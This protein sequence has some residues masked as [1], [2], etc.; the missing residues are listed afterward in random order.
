MALRTDSRPN[1]LLF[2]PDQLRADVVS[3]F[4]LAGSA[5]AR[6][7]ALDSLAERATSFTSA[8]SQHPVCG[9]SRASIMTGWYPHV[10]GHR[11]LTTP[12]RHDEPNLLR[13]CKDAGYH[14]AWAGHRG[15]TFAP[16]V[17]EASTDFSGWL[18]PPR[19]LHSAPTV[20]PGSPLH[21]AYYNGRRPRAVVDFDEATVRT[22]EAWLSSGPPE[23]WLLFV[24]LLFPHCPFETE[25]PWFSLHERQ[26]IPPPAPRG[27]V[28]R[29]PAFKTAL[30]AALGLDDL[31]DADWAELR[32]TY[33]GMVS[34]VDHH[35]GRVLDAVEH[36]GATERT[37][38]AF[39][40]DHGEYAGDQG[41]VEKWPSGLDAC[42]LRN[43]LLVALPGQ[44]EAR[45]CDALVEMVDLLPTLCTL[46]GVPVPHQH[47]GHDLGPLIDGATTELRD[48]AFSE[49]GFSRR[50]AGRLEASAGRY[51]A[52]GELQRSQPDLVGRAASVRTQ[53]WTYVHRL[54]EGPELYDRLADPFETVNLAGLAAQADDE[55]ELRHRLLEW[56]LDTAD[57]LPEPDLPRFPDIPHGWR[58]EAVR[59]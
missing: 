25:E 36:A 30:R 7:P 28:D 1:L 53:R 12:L 47:F 27:A 14:V 34:R 17:T 44:T 40:T 20:A 8:W 10:A 49:G 41:L 2:M 16:G 3:T 50:E 23:P 48:A 46:A 43:P 29:E 4:A 58:T 31:T 51:A 9:P 38:I 11:S 57:L 55:E 56:L 45:R 15:D 33:L 13:I 42:L 32:A 18:D 37:A 19:T 52:K 6:T 21:R 22:A 35:L 24:A 39:F 54:E 26:A 5:V 59:S